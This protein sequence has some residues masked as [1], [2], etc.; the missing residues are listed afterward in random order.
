MKK[1]LNKENK[2]TLKW[3]AIV[4]L[5]WRLSLSLFAFLGVKFILLRPDFLGP[6][7][8]ANFDGVHYLNIAQKGYFQFEQAFFPFYPFLVRWLGRFLLKDYLFTGLMV[9]HLAFFLSLFLFYKLVRIDHSEKIAR[10]SIFY[11]LVFPTSFF[12]AC[13]YSESLFLLLILGSF[14]F[15]RKQKWLWAGVLGAM[16]SATRLVGIFLFP[17]LLMEWYKS[18]GK[19]KKE[20]LKNILSLVLI[21]FGLFVYMAYLHQTTGDPLYFFHVQPLF[22]AQRSGSRLI[23]LY[24][25]FWRYLKMVLTTKWDVLY[26][27]V[28]LEALTSLLFLILAAL[29]YLWLPLSYF[30]FLVL[31]YL[32]PT[33][34]GTFSSMPRY[35]LVLFPGFIILARLAGKYP[36]LK[37]VYSIISGI[38]L[39]ISTILFTRGY[40]I[41]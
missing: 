15:A 34:T 30:V 33:L 24:Q 22:G 35:V 37:M 11:L 36:K 14:W 18:K 25:V 26:F 40:W 5:I 10:R 2:E 7:P 39:I 21:G 23:L 32:A 8:W 4:F 16:A 31:A 1:L 12:F 28:W 20:K 13:F 27:A 41:G 19:T 17:A 9:S 29:T 38:L 6:S 3:L